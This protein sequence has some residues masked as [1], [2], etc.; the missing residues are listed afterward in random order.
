[1]ACSR[2]TFPGLG[3][4]TNKWDPMALKMKAADSTE[5]LV[6]LPHHSIVLQKTVILIVSDLGTSDLLIVLF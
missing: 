3:L 2:V 1:M 6:C 5:T 4:R